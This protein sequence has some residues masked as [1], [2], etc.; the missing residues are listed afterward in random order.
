MKVPFPVPSSLVPTEWQH[1]RA[2]LLGL[3][4]RSSWVP[5]QLTKRWLVLGSYERPCMNCCQFAQDY[6]MTEGGYCSALVFHRHWQFNIPCSTSDAQCRGLGNVISAD[7]ALIRKTSEHGTFISTGLSSLLDNTFTCQGQQCF[8]VMH[9][10]HIL[11]FQGMSSRRC[12]VLRF[13]C[14]LQDRQMG[15]M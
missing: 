1:A 4:S 11:L 14:T 9:C 15:K 3:R 2:G 10:L 5:T 13:H 6:E 8:Q 12:R 7:V